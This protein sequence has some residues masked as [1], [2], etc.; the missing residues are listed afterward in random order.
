MSPLDI[1]VLAI[2]ISFIIAIFCGLSAMAPPVVT[3]FA[4]FSLVQAIIFAEAGILTKTAPDRRVAKIKGFMRHSSVMNE[5]V[6]VTTRIVLTV[7]VLIGPH[8]PTSLLAGVRIQG[9]GH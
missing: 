8:L 4:M 5:R 3:D 2:P 1:A 6:R 9:Q 7:T